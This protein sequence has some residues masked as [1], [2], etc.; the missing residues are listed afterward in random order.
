ML[1]E[2]SRGDTPLPLFTGP[3]P[4]E[5]VE[6]KRVGLSDAVATL[7]RVAGRKMR[8]VAPRAKTGFFAEA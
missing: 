4:M 6:G 8:W 5:G 3:V 7:F 2:S 1:R